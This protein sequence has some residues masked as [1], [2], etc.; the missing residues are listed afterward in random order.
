MPDDATASDR[1][2]PQP[3]ASRQ[4]READQNYRWGTRTAGTSPW[5]PE[6]SGSER[7]HSQYGDSEIEN[8][9]HEDPGSNREGV[10]SRP[11]VRRLGAGLVALPEFTSTDPA[12]AMLS[13][14]EVP[15]D[16]RFCW[17]CSQPVGRS[18]DAGP[19]RSSGTCASCGA[20]FNF[21]PLLNPGDLVADQYEVQGCLAYGGLGWIY[22]AR[23]RNVARRWVVLK[24]LQNPLDF[25][26]N[27]V[28]LAER[29]FLSEMA[30][31]AIVKIFNF[32]THRAGDG[33]SCGYIV[34][35]YIGGRSLKT[36]LDL[37]AP[38]RMPVAEAIAYVMEILPALDYL[39]SFGLAYNDLKPDNIM[40][41]EDEVKLI[42]LGAVAARQSGGSLYGTQGYQAPEYT[43]TGPTIASDIYTVGRT[44]AALTLD[45]PTDRRGRKLPG[46]PSADREPVLRRYPSFDRLLR[47]ATHPDPTQRFPSTFAM[48]R[49]LGGVLRAVLAA[50]TDRGH[51]QVSSVFGAPRGDF[52]VTALLRQT[53]GIIDGRY[54]PPTLDAASVLAALPVPL[55]DSEDPSYELVSP[56]L[57]G[58]PNQALDTLRLH[59]DNMSAGDIPQP[60]SFELEA[61]LTEIRAQL[62]L[63]RVRGA[64]ADLDRLRAEYGDDWRLDWYTGIAELGEGRIERAYRLFDLVH[65]AVPGE[66]APQLALAATAEL[67]VQLGAESGDGERWARI[68]AA[69]YRAA[70]QVDRGLASAAFGL[71]RRQVADGD[72]VGA[73]ATL[74]RMPEV[75]RHY[76]A[77][78]LTACLLLVSRPPQELTQADLN[79]AQARLQALP[80]DPRLLQ[81][82]A[83]VLGAALS[84]VRAGGRPEPEQSTVLGFPCTAAGLREGLET[85]L[86]TVARTSPRR[87]Q[88]YALV[89]L[90]NRVRPRSW[91]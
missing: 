23:D 59:R 57:H 28:A 5:S 66:V 17:K 48:H 89:D 35:E 76:N 51:P 55:I 60:E 42:D 83:V 12:T 33:A 39:H 80:D 11:S 58:D 69:H 18:G 40:V 37:H 91:W 6:F 56:L 8:S 34:M 52:G 41:S 4:L 31:P 38:A 78:R 26:A 45:L 29:Q 71:A 46:L 70:W 61:A 64:R 85:V 27:V 84:W 82:Q 22:L 10:R 14:P 72:V 75:S 54:R 79:E 77:A 68:A 50:D 24:G 36:V 47:R 21:R 74:E 44:L 3:W 90:A 13:D 73:V 32:V 49:Q 88:R 43:S 87:L 7:S 53:D 19:A 25:E 2:Y 15:E 81:L 63:R 62:D 9:E 16:K 86:R 20:P 67:L 65:G 30:H 1:L